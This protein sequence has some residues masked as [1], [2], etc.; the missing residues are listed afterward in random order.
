MDP[1]FP[2]SRSNKSDEGFSFEVAGEI[3]KEFWSSSV[4]MRTIFKEAARRSKLDY[5]QPHTFRHAAIYRALL[6]LKG[7]LEYKAISQNFGHEEIG[8]IL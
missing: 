5:F 8:T 2:K 7:G 6:F 1:L 3:T 4:S